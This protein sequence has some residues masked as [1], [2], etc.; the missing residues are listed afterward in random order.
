[1]LHL[2]GDNR[3]WLI[4]VYWDHLVRYL[5]DSCEV[6]A[7]EVFSLRQSLMQFL[8]QTERSQQF[9]KDLA[10]EFLL[11]VQPGLRAWALLG[12][13]MPSFPGYLCPWKVS[14]LL[15]GF[16]LNQVQIQNRPHRQGRGVS[17]GWSY[18]VLRVFLMFELLGMFAIERGP[19][20]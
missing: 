8:G 17:W 9:S 3:Q 4:N 1:M 20:L 7:L 5:M 16:M 15:L 13:C 10:E 19:V 14:A 18:E 2:W 12:G 11:T 6:C